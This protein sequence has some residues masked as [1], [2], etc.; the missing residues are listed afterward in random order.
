V[1]EPLPAELA[2][3][4]DAAKAICRHHARSFYFASHFLP[5]PKRDH[6]YAVYGFCRLLDDAADLEPTPASVERFADLLDRVYAGDHA[7]ATASMTDRDRLAIDAFAHTVRACSIPKQYFDDLAEGCRMDF[8]VTRYATWPQ[9]EKYCYHV[10]GVVGL[11]MCRVFDLR[12]ETALAQAVHMGN[13][14]QLTNILRD[15]REDFDRARV[16]LPAEDLARFGLGE[17]DL[18]SRV[19]DERF[20]SLM[21]FEIARAKDLYAKAAVGLSKLPDDG[22]RLT[23]CVMAVVY[24]GILGAIER[25]GY[26]VFRGRAHIGTTRKLLKVLAARKLKRWQPPAPLPN[27][28][29]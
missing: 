15:V 19:V 23:A 29:G 14:M 11:I 6:A 12:D 13:A 9:L 16:Y 25:Q 26:D 24:S 1:P 21:K 22:S 3:A 2:P 5:R 27:V 10:A 8:T 18:A 17:T 7:G 28:F 4:Y 20:R